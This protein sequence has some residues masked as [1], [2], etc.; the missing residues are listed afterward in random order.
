[1]LPEVAD[2]RGLLARDRLVHR[3]EVRQLL[4][5]LDERERTVLLGHF[6]LDDG[7]TPATYEQLGER[8]GL[9]Q[10]RVRQIERTA[11]AKLR[12]GMRR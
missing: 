6:G 7:S 1:M 9:S 4:S 10:Q 5:R 12:A 2:A 3:D 8:L 11:I